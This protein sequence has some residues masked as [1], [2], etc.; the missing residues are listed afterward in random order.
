MNKI[1]ALESLR[2][3]A[4]LIVVFHHF[5]YAFFPS[6]VEGRGAAPLHS[7]YEWL[8]LQTPL[9]ALVNGH[10]AVLCFFVLS[11]FV[12]SYGFFVRS[13]DLVSAT[14]KRYFRLVPIVLASVLL[15]YFL[16]KLELYY[17]QEVSLLTGSEWL[18][19]FWRE[20]STILNAIWQGLVG[21]FAVQPNFSSLNPVLW[22]IYYELIGSLL[23]FSFLALAGNDKRRWA[24]YILLVI[25]FSNTYYI[26]FIIGAL[27]CDLYVRHSAIFTAIGLLKKGYKLALIAL[28]IYFASYPAYIASEADIGVMHRP[29]VIFSGEDF[30]NLTKNVLY[31]FASL[32]LITLLL[33]SHKVQLFFK[34]RPLILL[35]SLSYSLYATHLLLLGSVVMYAFLL[36]SRH[37]PYNYAAAVS[38]V[39]YIITAVALAA[40]FRKYIDIP[41]IQLSSTIIRFTKLDRN[42]QKRPEASVE[43][44]L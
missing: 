8:I 33:T 44:L 17:N 34:L 1:L 20:D 28:A 31:T 6:M 26:A 4:A 21:S 2:G 14:V 30:V 23:V 13:I 42:E 7:N 36:L 18:S 9:N 35:G 16:L 3:L 11:G 10:F 37:V 25:I 5:A 41:S 39:I 27:L 29:I 15:S 24:V 40:I 32:I 12:L 22:T 38:F 19:L 43:S